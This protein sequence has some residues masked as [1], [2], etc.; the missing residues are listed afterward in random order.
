MTKNEIL[1]QLK[2]NLEMRGRC[3]ERVRNYSINVWLFQD[4][5][6][7]PADKMCEEKIAQYLHHLLK[8][9]NLTASSVNSQNVT[10]K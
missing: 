5:F 10:I 7:K 3:F 2:I 8:H 9:K 4:Y 6:D 1:R